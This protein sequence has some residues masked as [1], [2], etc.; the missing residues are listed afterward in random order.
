MAAVST[1]RK[2]A[3]TTTSCSAT[4][5]ATPCTAAP[6]TTSCGVTGIPANNNEQQRDRLR[7]GSG[8]DWLYS[9]H[10]SN[11]INGGPGTD[12]VW[13]Y[14]G[15]GTIDCGPGEHDVARVRL[16]APFTVRNCETI[17]HFCA[18]GPDGHGGCLRPGETRS[19]AR[20]RGGLAGG[21][22]MA[23]LVF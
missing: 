20:P 22:G 18:F 21:S 11:D 8:N 15:R 10:G 16:G 23:G 2:A 9:S 17:G 19:A 6:G 14:Y 4:T 13:A 7:G 3:G 12:H 5:G 1:G